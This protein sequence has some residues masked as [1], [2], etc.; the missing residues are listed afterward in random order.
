VGKK[1][2]LII[3]QGGTIHTW[4]YQSIPVALNNNNNNNNN[5]KCIILIT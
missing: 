2:L 1:S 5:N 4:Q 3:I